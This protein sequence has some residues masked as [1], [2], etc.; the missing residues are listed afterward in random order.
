MIEELTPEAAERLTLI[1]GFPVTAADV[2]SADGKA[3]I[4]ILFER[5]VSVVMPV[6]V[7][8]LA[9]LLGDARVEAFIAA[10]T[11]V[12]VAF[13]SADDAKRLAAIIGGGGTA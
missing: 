6:R 7:G 2:L 8:C 3:T 11:A 5:D 13:E 1:A 4:D 10:G 12:V 9:D